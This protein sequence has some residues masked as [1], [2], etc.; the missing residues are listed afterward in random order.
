MAEEDRNWI[1]CRIPDALLE[2]STCPLLK[3]R[4]LASV[5][6]PMLQEITTSSST[7]CR[8]A[9][10]GMNAW[11]RHK[12]EDRV[13]PSLPKLKNQHGLK[14]SEWLYDLQCCWHWDTSDTLRLAPESTTYWNSIYG[15]CILHKKYSPLMKTQCRAVTKH[16]FWSQIT[17]LQIPAPFCSGLGFRQSP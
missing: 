1:N 10:E 13:I 17:W 16:R 11:G 2:S 6:L 3:P 4:A 14:I 9:G 15:N 12:I 5:S 7:R 8:G